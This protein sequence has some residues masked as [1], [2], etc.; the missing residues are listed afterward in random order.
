MNVTNAMPPA[1]GPA[2]NT[3]AN[4]SAGTQATG[5]GW[6]DLFAALL[7][8]LAAAP[9][10]VAQSAEQSVGSDGGPVGECEACAEDALAE[11]AIDA[12]ETG[13]IP[14]GGEAGDS[15]PTIP[16]AAANSVAPAVATVPLASS[17]GSASSIPID[18]VSQSMSVPA[19]LPEAAKPIGNEATSVPVNASQ[20]T[21]ADGDPPP[22]LLP[23][24]QSRGHA[25]PCR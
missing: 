22:V 7:A 1:Q 11:P 5:G 14:I 25:D 9:K 19:S 23:N 16:V 21:D 3:A 10:A 6:G 12:G 17:P 13:A 15:A 18:V 20:T 8:S 24:A 4:V 2:A